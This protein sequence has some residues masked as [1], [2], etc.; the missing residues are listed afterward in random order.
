[1]LWFCDMQAQIQ[2]RVRKMIIETYV[3]EGYQEGHS[4]G[5]QTLE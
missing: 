1:M 2:R 3:V 5:G 4:E